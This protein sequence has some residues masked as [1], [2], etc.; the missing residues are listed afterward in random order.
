MSLTQ[1]IAS[2]IRQAKIQGDARGVSD[3]QLRMTEKGAVLTNLWTL[4]A[5]L[6][7]D[8]DQDPFQEKNSIAQ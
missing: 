4:R 2:R 3:F 5:E 8:E 7:F 6:P 1:Q